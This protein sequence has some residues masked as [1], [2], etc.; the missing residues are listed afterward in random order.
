[1]QLINKPIRNRKNLLTKEKLWVFLKI[2]CL[3]KM[4]GTFY[5]KKIKNMCF[6]LLHT[7]PVCRKLQTTYFRLSYF[8]L[9]LYE[10][11]PLVKGFLHTLQWSVKQV[12]ALFS[13]YVQNM[14][15]Y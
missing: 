12:N 7:L 15:K 8:L 6:I 13:S 4:H 3:P 2:I 5:K 11:R 9:K 14:I 1:M 10:I